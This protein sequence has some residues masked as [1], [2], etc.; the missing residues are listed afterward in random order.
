MHFCNFLNFCF[1]RNR[2][3]IFFQIVAQNFLKKL[4]KNFPLIWFLIS[5]KL[6]QKFS[7]F[8]SKTVWY[9]L[10]YL[11]VQNVFNEFERKFSQSQFK[12]FLQFL[13]TMRNIL[14]NSVKFYSSFTKISWK[15]DF[16]LY[17]EFKFS[18]FFS[19]LHTNCLLICLKFPLTL[20][21]YYSL[22]FFV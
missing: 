18:H 9:F 5:T 10:K 3:N 7:K 16:S 19:K 15:F 20:T 4:V 8:F 14:K 21:R 2:S 13:N 11:T 6:N 22:K 1:T 17:F 12:T